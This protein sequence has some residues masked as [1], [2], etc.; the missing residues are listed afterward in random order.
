KQ[1][2]LGLKSILSDVNAGVLGPD[3]FKEF[4]IVGDPDIQGLG[5]P[6]GAG[7]PPRSGYRLGSDVIDVLDGN[8]E[9]GPGVVDENQ[10]VS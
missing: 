6:S 7:E 4:L 2:P 3:D 5:I 10:D 9:D 1:T 8:P